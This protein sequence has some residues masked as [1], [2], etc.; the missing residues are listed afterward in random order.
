MKL[1]ARARH[2]VRLMVELDRLGASTRPV[3]LAKISSTTGISRRFLEQMTIS[4]KSHLLLRGV[5][6]R[7]GGYVFAKPAG[8]ITIGAVLRAVNGPINMSVCV[9]APETCLRSE[10]CECRLIWH[11]LQLRINRILD[12]VTIADLSD[13]RRMAHIREHVLHEADGVPGTGLLGL[14][15]LV[16]GGTVEGETS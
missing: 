5:A 3:D 14:H 13:K 6:G 8:A 4:L 12:E 9:A 16:E 2:A 10:F 11:L 1:P 7:N 15:S